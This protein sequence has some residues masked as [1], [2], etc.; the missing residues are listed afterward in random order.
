MAGGLDSVT[1]GVPPSIR[2]LLEHQVARLRPADQELL[3]AASV[4]GVE[5]AVAAVA[6]GVQHTGEDVEVQCDTLARQHQLVQARG[7]ALW[8][9]GTVI[10]TASAMPCIR[11]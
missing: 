6:A 7:T 10:A 2:H 4:A 1:V 8:P 3:A 11:N 5:F 9:D